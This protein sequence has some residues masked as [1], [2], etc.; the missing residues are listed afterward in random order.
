MVACN[1]AEGDKAA[2]NASPADAKTG[3]AV[4]ATANTANPATPAEGEVDPNLP[5]T[6]VEFAE[7]EHDFG[8]IN[9]GDKVSHVFKFKNTGKEPLIIASAKG[10]CGCTVPE[11]PKE[12]IAPGAES[13]I[14]VEFNSKGKKNMQTKTV[15]INANTDPNPMRLTIKADVTPAPGSETEGAQGA[16]GGQLKVNPPA[17]AGKK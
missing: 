16:Q 14:L 5:K 9:E 4:D 11:Y 3:T 15:T 17:P 13:Q 2:G 12:P 8:K 7:M 10:S 1:Q 6:T